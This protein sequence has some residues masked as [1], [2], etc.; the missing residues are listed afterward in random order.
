MHH[1]L[2]FAKKLDVGAYAKV[3]VHQLI[4]TYGISFIYFILFYFTSLII[5]FSS[6][7]STC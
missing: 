3:K 1:N 4:L 5:S 7:L 2:Q 6:T